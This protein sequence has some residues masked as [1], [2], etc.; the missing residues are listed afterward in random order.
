[1]NNN[2]TILLRIVKLRS[3]SSPL[4][5]LSECFHISPFSLVFFQLNHV[6]TK[7][8]LVSLFTLIETKFQK[9]K[10]LTCKTYGIPGVLC[11]SMFSLTILCHCVSTRWMHNHMPKYLKKP[12][13]ETKIFVCHSFWMIKVNI[14]SNSK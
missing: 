1:M 10:W 9:L 13:I 5:P 12:L 14:W 6:K 7:L 3:L 4:K 11:V 8:K 2:K